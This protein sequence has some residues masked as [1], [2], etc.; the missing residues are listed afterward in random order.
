MGRA[1]RTAIAAAV[2]G[3]VA[4]LAGVAAAAAAAA[5]GGA[6]R[7]A[8]AAHSAVSDRSLASC[9]AGLVRSRAHPIVVLG[10]SFTA[11]VGP[12]SPA[13]S[14][15]ADLARL[16]HRDTVIYGV[17]GAG[18]VRPGAGRHG[19]VAAEAAA[20][21]L[22]R[23]APSLVI[24]QAGH[25]DIGVPP[26]QEQ[27]RVER[28]IAQIRA[29]APGAKV[30]VLTVFPGHAPAG[31]AYLTDQAIVAGAR[32]ADREVIIMDPLTAGWMY[33]R[34][35]DGLHPTA[36]GDSWLAAEVASVLRFYGVRPETARP[37]AVVVCARSSAAA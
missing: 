22:R 11:G 10:A 28:A 9:E 26:A 3:A 1:S 15:A 2:A 36:A 18:Y 6:P 12:G 13:R 30:A 17:A 31:A 4:L 16:L 21:G 19:P 27:A 8:V 23:L 20:L 37:G 25:N 32:A 33:Q 35:R 5:G 7:P 29:A 24:V 34:A 14:W